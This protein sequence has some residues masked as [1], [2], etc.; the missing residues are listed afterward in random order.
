MIRDRTIVCVASSWFDHPTSKHHLMR[1]LA[2]DNDVI[3]VNY[4]ASRRPTLS[5]EDAAAGLRRLRRIWAGPRRVLP[6]LEVLSPPLVPL[7]GC[8]RVRALNAYL[9]ARHVQG[10]LR[11]R[12]PR[13]VQLWLFTPDAPELIRRLPAERVVYYCVDDFAG[14]SGFDAALVASLET[15]TIG[16][17]DVVIATSEELYAAHRGRH[18]RV[19]LVSHGVDFAHF[20]AAPHWPPERRPPELGQIRR[21]ILGYFGQ[22][23][24][25]L[26]LELLAAA[27]RRRPEWSFVLI[28]DRTHPVGP[29]LGLPNVWL[30]G[31]RPYEELP[32]YCAAFDVGLIPFRMNRLVRAANPI[33]LR[34][35][36]AAGLP[37]VSSPIPAALQYAPAVY[38]ARTTDEFLAA[39]TAALARTDRASRRARQE[40]VRG[41][42]WEVCAQ[43]VSG[44]VM[45]AGRSSP[46]SPPTGPAPA[47]EP[48]ACTQ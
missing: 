42:S 31:P 28:G 37:V 13:P 17:S 47:V 33:K 21:P 10:A 18:P 38:P 6:R 41:E 45:A 29:L 26:D 1:I 5:R 35:Y 7:P 27:A 2:R 3:W 23:S 4:H 25:Y 34:E 19:H 44:L 14:F 30:L 48:V 20:A 40:L 43:R 15:R 36:L 11:R 32:G 8:R 46:E 9:L 22:I 24:D 39:C 12:P 16:L